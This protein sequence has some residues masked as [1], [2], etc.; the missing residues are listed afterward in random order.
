[1]SWLL[2]NTNWIFIHIP[3][4]GGTSIRK[5]L[6]R[7]KYNLTT[8][9]FSKDQTKDVFKNSPTR[10]PTH[11]KLS[12]YEKIGLAIND[13]NYFAQ[14]RNPYTRM[15]SVYRFIIKQD[16]KRYKGLS[17]KLKADREFYYN[18]CRKLEK[19]QFSGFIKNFSDPNFAND[20]HSKWSIENINQLQFG[21]QLQKEW[22]TNC[23]TTLKIFKLEDVSQLNSWLNMMGF[24]YNYNHEKK[25]VYKD[26]FSFYTQEIADIVYKYFEQDFD[27]YKYPRFVL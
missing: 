8:L 19:M 23:P 21:W 15:V 12:E 2:H 24:E 3:K 14:V 1:M 6:Q 16:M 5:S 18:R 22:L 7:F 27:E 26:H 17:T 20:W 10:A 13:Y 25:Q 4:T 9:E 11:I